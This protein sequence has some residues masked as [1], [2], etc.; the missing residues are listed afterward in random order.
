MTANFPSL[1]SISILKQC[2]VN[3]ITYASRSHLT[4]EYIRERQ[5]YDYQ[6]LSA[7]QTLPHL[8][9]PCQ[10]SPLHL[11]QAPP[12][13]KKKPKQNHHSKAENIVLV[14]FR[15]KSM[16]CVLTSIDPQRCIVF[17]INSKKTLMIVSQKIVTRESS[18]FWYVGL[19]K[20]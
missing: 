1:P 8:P 11:A 17:S 3:E 5:C 6:L 10:T 19:F 18:N 4:V 16:I 9:A 14:S 2:E 12:P 20:N 7:I 15:Y 13:Q